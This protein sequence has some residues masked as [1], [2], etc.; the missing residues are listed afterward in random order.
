MNG[1]TFFKGFFR[2]T[3]CCCNSNITVIICHQT[4]TEGL[5]NFFNTVVSSIDNF[6]FIID[7]WDIGDTNCQT[8]KC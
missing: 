7:N 5:V 3:P 8:S 1:R 4:T 2:F 6:L